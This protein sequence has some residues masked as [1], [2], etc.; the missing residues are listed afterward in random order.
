M[1]GFGFDYCLSYNAVQRLV[2]V[3]FLAADL[4]RH[5]RIR[6]NGLETSDHPI[7]RHSDSY[8]PAAIRTV[9]ADTPAVL[10]MQG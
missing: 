3:P 8:S 4:H 6:R 2:A 9:A 1:A 7:E 10:V 5:D